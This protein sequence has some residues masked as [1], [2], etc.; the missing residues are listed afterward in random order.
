MYFL[1]KDSVTSKNTW[2]TFNKIFELF[3]N[4]N[5]HDTW[6][7]KYLLL[8]IKCQKTCTKYNA[9]NNRKQ[10]VNQDSPNRICLFKVV[11]IIKRKK[12]YTCNY[13]RIKN[14][15]VPFKNYAFQE[16]RH[17]CGNIIRSIKNRKRLHLFVS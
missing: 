7:C 17:F 1:R 16:K 11:T 9:I 3:N 5:I 8:I 10:I 13:Y 6:Y 4:L 15:I 14:V 2:H 12:I